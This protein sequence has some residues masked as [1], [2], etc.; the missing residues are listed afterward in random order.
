M[1]HSYSEKE[2]ELLREGGQ[3]LARIMSGV[4]EY[5]APGISVHDIEMKVRHL[6]DA[7]ECTSATIGFK[8]QGAPYAFPSACCVSV[9]D[10]TVHGI[11]YNNQRI[12]VEG[13]IVSVD[14]VIIYQEMFVDV[15]RTYPVGTISVQDKEL[16]YSARKTTDAAIKA[17]VVGN[18][19]DD[20]G[21]AAQE[22]AQR[23]GHQTV[24][25]LGGHGVGRSIHM[26]PFIPNFGNSGFRDKIIAGMVLAVEPIISAGDWRVDLAD[27]GW[28]FVSRNGSKT[29]QFE[30]TVLV[31][32][33]GPEILT[34][35][36]D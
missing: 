33:Q 26:P 7:E 22:T 32:E 28:L 25:E 21:R 11:A 30:E 13:D 9:N 4:E 23:Y 5:I 20:I 16:L 6:I 34:V 17:T 18:T 14:V 31:T 2:I 3:R 24:R 36:H 27:D 29:A 8:P 35:L 1:R 15:C 10:E 12:L 19:V